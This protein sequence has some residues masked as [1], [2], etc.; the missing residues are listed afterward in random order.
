MFQFDFL[1]KLVYRYI[2]VLLCNR[3]MLNNNQ[4]YKTEFTMPTKN[5]SGGTLNYLTVTVYFI[6]NSSLA[7]VLPNI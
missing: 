3:K 4:T 6:C 5:I 1:I 2:M 7:F